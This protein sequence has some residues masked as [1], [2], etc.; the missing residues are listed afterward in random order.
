MELSEILFVIM[1]KKYVKVL[2]FLAFDY[3]III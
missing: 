2:V 3:E 1:Y